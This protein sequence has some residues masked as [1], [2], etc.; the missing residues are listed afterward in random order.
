M[1][2][3]YIEDNLV[4]YH[5][6]EQMICHSTLVG[7]ELIGRPDLARGLAVLKNEKVDVLLLN[8]VLPDSKGLETLQAVQDCAPALPIIVLSGSEDEDAALEA[9]KSGAQDYLV[10]SCINASL[11]ARSIRYAAERKQIENEL[12]HRVELEKLAAGISNRFINLAAEN[13]EEEIAAALNQLGEFTRSDGAFLHLF[14][15]EK[16][17]IELSYRW[18][19]EEIRLHE[20]MG[21]GRS[22]PVCNWLLDTLRRQDY[23]YIPSQDGL[24][25][26]AMAFKEDLARR[27]IQSVLMVPLIVNND[28][29]GWLELQSRHR[30]W[31]WPEAD[32]HLIYLA[33]D[34]FI[35]VFTYQL[36]EKVRRESE[37]LY[38]TLARSLPDH[39]V[40]LFD[41]QGRHLI[42]GGAVL[43]RSGLADANL[44]GKTLQEVWP[45]GESTGL[46]K[47]YRDALAG[48]S[49]RFEFTFGGISFDAHVLPVLD[50]K[51][52]IF[53]GM[54][55]VQDISEYK[56]SQDVL[57]DS[58]E[59]LR[60]LLDNIPMG[61]YR[62]AIGPK[63]EF[64]MVNP[65]F[66]KMFGIGSEDELAGMT[67]VDLYP[68]PVDRGHFSD[69]VLEEKEV[70]SLLM[71]FRRV[72]G[73]TLWGSVSS[74]ID[75]DVEGNPAYFDNVIEDVTPR[76]EAESA[77]RTL[78]EH[79]LQALII[80][81]GGR[82]VFANP[83]VTTIS[84]YTLEELLTL[85]PSR[86]LGLIHPQDRLWVYQSIRTLEREQLPDLRHSFRVLRK[87]G[88]VRWVE[89]VN[90]RVEFQGHS[91]IQSIHV[92]ITERRQA[93][94]KLH[95]RL[96]METLISA[97]S[98]RFIDLPL[99]EVDNE[100]V[101]AL[102]ELGQFADVD[103]CEFAILDSGGQKVLL[104]YRWRNPA[105]PPRPQGLS[106]I[107]LTR[108]RWAN[109][110][111][112]KNNL[113]QIE[114]LDK[115]PVEAGEEKA[116]FLSQGIRSLL[117][118][119]LLP[120]DR[121][122]GFLSFSVERQDKN[123][124]EE[125]VQ[126]L[127][128]AGEVFLNILARKWAEESLRK[129]EAQ[130]RL[131]ADSIQDIIGLH[132]LDGN[133]LYMSPSLQKVT[134]LTTAEVSGRSV[135]SFAKTDSLSRS[136]LVI[137]ELLAK[138]RDVTFEW[139]LQN[140]TGRLLWIETVGHPILDKERIAVRW[141]SSSRD[142]TE[143]RRAREALR[144]AN[145]KLQQTVDNLERRNRDSGL[146]IAM[147]DMLQSCLVQDEVYLVVKN[148]G[149]KLF[150]SFCGS[151]YLL[152]EASNSA[153][154]VA[155][156]GGEDALPSFS[157]DDCWA[158]RR[159]RPHFYTSPGISLVCRHVNRARQ[160][161]AL[162][163]PLVALGESVGLFHLTRHES[164][165]DDHIYQLATMVS[166]RIALALVNLKLR[167][168]L[169][170]QSIRD[171]LT[172]LYNRRYLLET[173]KRE[174]SRGSRRK[175]SIGV[176]M[177]DIDH[178]KLFND[179]YGHDVGDTL[180]RALGNY[181]LK[182]IRGEDVACRYGGEEFVLVLPDTSLKD[183]L[184]RANELREGITKLMILHENK[185]MG[186]IT[187]SMG[188]AEFPTYGKTMD[189][190]LK[191][192]DTALYRAKNGGRNRVAGPSDF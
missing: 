186:G 104:D 149:L 168:T 166:E 184:L 136:L 173:M 58:E 170:E 50:D 126:I 6:I 132:D 11:L 28:L 93:E 102:G 24:P 137:K 100:I 114:N 13:L 83:A 103:N 52:E 133:T 110:E 62:N 25:D 157:M 30:D 134:G 3:L 43:G 21:A 154:L 120:Y 22:S 23:L 10:K 87:D 152:E 95:R 31:E 73:T 178:F 105:L 191:C 39:A 174:I 33:R 183:T 148:Y 67:M 75:Y 161:C 109:N 98:K 153:R 116:I 88:D 1:K 29:V 12:L 48:I 37:Q 158:L 60:T 45:D 162:C 2:I 91:A 4:D 7:V 112:L 35:N 16:E 80:L 79:S 177:M 46:F 124:T 130:Y 115:L 125:D 54:A 142:I 138:G 61:I 34:I 72:D 182:N 151:L 176:I 64:L 155:G 172:L 86:V 169:R 117:V 119:S 145:L 129:S 85:T 108:F 159:S 131:L 94:E 107:Y 147:G 180:L 32:L 68:N 57:R 42:A 51:G 65:A 175:S 8:P 185:T 17:V 71:K 44:L 84:G 189:A 56:H 69:L 121:P 55:I 27:L 164:C 90:V 9:V 101:T 53:A 143:R 123:W 20:E 66:L 188:V 41:N 144:S 171:P 63:G 141:I 70:H 118:A 49:S 150:P 163:I 78:V 127:R 139:Q 160:S 59:R 179:S 92:D 89:S 77:Y 40:L 187:V 96:T 74:R 18:D 190:L 15:A 106:G 181:L 135:F 156:W 19:Q 82:I 192:A 111:I 165:S 36:V 76:I 146:L 47:A 38:R 14:S 99:E 113:I 97:I 128:M 81:Q 167:D 122:G 5:L 26:E 140:K